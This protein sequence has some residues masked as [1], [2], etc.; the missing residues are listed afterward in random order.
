MPRIV[1]RIKPLG[2]LSPGV[3]SFASTPA[4]N[5]IKIVHK[6]PIP[7]LLLNLFDGYSG[8]AFNRYRRV[9]ARLPRGDDLLE[10]IYQLH[11]GVRGRASRP[12]RRAADPFA[13]I[14]SPT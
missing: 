12:T 8:P 10:C 3:M 9:K 2:S 14:T 11:P 4:I 7:S 1:V 5:P 13:S 6:I